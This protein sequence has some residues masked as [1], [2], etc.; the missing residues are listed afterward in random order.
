MT[1]TEA[2]EAQSDISA[3]EPERRR[4][5][6]QSKI[7]RPSTRPSDSISRPR[8]EP[9][10][11]TCRWSTRRQPGPPDRSRLGRR[12]MYRVLDRFGWREDLV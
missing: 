6:R 2:T 7:R 10:A 1:E 4:P 3:A 8:G 5:P 12:N 11:S 9:S